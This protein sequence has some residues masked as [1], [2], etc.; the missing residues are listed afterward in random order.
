MLDSNGQ[1]Q[2]SGTFLP[3][4]SIDGP[5]SWV[6]VL[7]QGYTYGGYWVNE[8]GVRYTGMKT[9]PFGQNK[10]S[11]LGEPMSNLG[12]A[13]YEKGQNG[14]VPYGGESFLPGVK[15]PT[16][17]SGQTTELP[18]SSSAAPAATGGGGSYTVNVTIAGRTSTVK[19][20]S[21]ADADALQALLQQLEDSAGAG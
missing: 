20:A 3:A 5:W 14:P 12:T 17:P 21:R 18:P 19:V 2:T 15:S 8:R 4:P 16:N 13:G 9:A 10:S 6:G 7:N 1:R 11:F